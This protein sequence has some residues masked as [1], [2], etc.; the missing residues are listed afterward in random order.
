MIYYLLELDFN[1]IFLA[2]SPKK[3]VFKT[4]GD[5]YGYYWAEYFGVESLT[6]NWGWILINPRGDMPFFI[7]YLKTACQL[8]DWLFTTCLFTP[9]LL[10]R[11]AFLPTCLFTPLPHSSSAFH[12]TW[13]ELIN[14]IVKYL[15]SSNHKFSLWLCQLLVVIWL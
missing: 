10:N 3:H 13:M 1:L 5:K 15:L 2:G 8:T 6:L 7:D 11:H 14:S 9:L 4:K 12:Y